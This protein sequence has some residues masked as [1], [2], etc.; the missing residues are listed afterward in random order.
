MARGHGAGRRW[1]LVAAGVVMLLALP[2]VLRL[3]PAGDDGRSAADLRTAV[4]AGADQGWSGIA[5]S[6][7]GLAL[8]E[9]DQLGTI[10]DLFS[11][12]TRMRV[13]WRGPEDHRID[14]V[15]ATG[16]TDL[17]RTAAGRWTWDYQSDRAGWTPAAG[18]TGFA[19]PAATDLLPST[20]TRRLLSE[21]DDGELSRIGSARV[22]GRAALG[23]RLV[24]ADPGASV[25]RVDVWVDAET[26][27]LP[28]QVQVFDQST[29]TVPALDTRLLEVD[30]TAPDP[31]VIAFRPPPSA[32]IRSDDPLGLLR[33]V[34]D[35]LPDVAFPDTLAGLPRR[36]VTGAPP[37]IGLY[38][39][40]VTLLAVIPLPGRAAAELR[41]AADADPAAVH[42]QLGSRL[43]AGPIG[44]LLTGAP[45]NAYL[46]TGT[47]TPETLAQ[48]A[49]ALPGLGSQ[50]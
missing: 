50:R 40:G 26:G 31:A 18:I 2:L 6:S 35:R 47:V 39:R 20:L 33:D 29:G 30:P 37:S 44:I 7:G 5:E 22:A 24:P 14:V 48:A 38:G 45:R 17:R 12:R 41:R 15:T 23:L 25:A 46:L 13:W 42:D 8:P 19:L 16:E 4:L 10:A 27:W 21:A 49:L 9:T 1:T 28:L 3:W 43:T 32:D 36:D 34:A 11:D